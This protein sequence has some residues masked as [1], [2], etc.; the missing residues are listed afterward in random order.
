M[1]RNIVFTIFNLDVIAEDVG[2]L[3]RESWEKQVRPKSKGKCPQGGAR[4]N[5]G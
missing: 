5:W 1:L 2:S 3:K 4:K